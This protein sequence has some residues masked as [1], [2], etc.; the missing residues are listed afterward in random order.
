MFSPSPSCGVSQYVLRVHAISS[1]AVVSAQPPS[2]LLACAIAAHAVIVRG[3]VTDPLGAVVAGARVQLIQG[4]QVA[5]VAFT[6]PNGTFEIRSTESGRFI[7]LTSAA[8]FTPAIGQD[9][10]GGRTDVVTR[11]VTLEIATVTAQVSVTA[12]GIPTPIQ[13]ISSAVTLIPQSDL[14]TRV[15]I[16]DDLR[17][18]PGVV[19][20]QTGQYGGV[21]SLFV[22]GGNS[23][24]NKVLID[25]VPANDVGGIFD[26]GTVSSTG[27]DRPRTLSRP[28]LRPL[29]HRRRSLRRQPR[30]PARQL[31][32]PR[33]QLLRRRRQLPH[34][35]QRGRPL[36]RL[37]Q[38]RLLRSFQPLRHLQRPP[39][40]RFHSAT[41]VANL[42]YN[43]TANTQA[44]FTIRNAV[45]A[46]GL[47][48][49]HD[50]YGI[51]ADGK[52]ADQDIYSGLTLGNRLEG[53]WH[54][55]VR[56]GIARKR[57]QEHAVHQRRHAHH[58]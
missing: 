42:G 24:A 16:V 41:S 38:A 33:A 18:A 51:S 12:T 58:L 52:Q 3:T 15:G 20:V 31:P 23:T 7:L 45:S 22:R 19:V 57:E 36:R 9:F 11:N 47:P 1:R 44:R 28:Q 54:N 27:L 43:I 39:R 4:K 25:G 32:A 48:Q 37:E 8:T 34:L 30:N 53:N 29:R 17:Q 10:Y 50:F 5:A 46:T 13:Q 56:Y 49:A 35:P 2:C 55:L 26:F 6:D 40:D 14:A 21:T